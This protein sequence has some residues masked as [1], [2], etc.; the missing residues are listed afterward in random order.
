MYDMYDIYI[1]H[2]LQSYSYFSKDVNIHR[3][4]FHSSD[5]KIEISKVAMPYSRMEEHQKGVKTIRHMRK[6]RTCEI[7]FELLQS[8][9]SELLRRILR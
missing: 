5:Y 9:K 1:I 3:F 8:S 4:N 2:V 6:K 7:S